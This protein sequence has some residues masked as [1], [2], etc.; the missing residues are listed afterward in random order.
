VTGLAAALV[1]GLPLLVL[2]GISDRTGTVR[3]QHPA[4]V[5]SRADAGRI[6]AG[7]SPYTPPPETSPRGREAFS[8]SFRLDPP[9]EIRPS[10][11]LLPPG[12]SVLAGL[13]RP[14]GVRDL[15]LP[16]FLALVVL[17][18]VLAA[19]TDGRRR[20]TALAL[21]LL[22]SPIAIGTVLGAP[23]AL[24]LT[25][26]VAAWP[27][28]RGRPGLASGLLAGAAMAL[29]H[30]AALAVP[31][32]L[33][34]SG[35]RR[36]VARG[37]AAALAAYLL[38]VGPVALLDPAAFSARLGER[39]ASGPG[40]GLFNLLAYRGMESS[41]GAYALAALEPLVL[42]AL[43]LWLLKR[44]WPPLALG[45]I[46]SLAGI[47]VAPAVSPEAVAVPLLLLGLAAME[48]GEEAGSGGVDKRDTDPK[49]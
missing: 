15:R 24:S 13:V 35:N 45:G 25:A 11:P 9:A 30:R 10:A 40:L 20:R 2:V 17:G 6:L 44:P 22:A 3:A 41:A 42:A 38:V 43:V 21:A 28:G 18:G 32:L 36:S 33:L 7:R 46:A 1:V 14:L 8:G 31:F 48:G 47:V 37:V 12:P 49:D 23:F 27:T 34:A 16:A 4:V 39:T 5:Q 26:L 29:D 19:R